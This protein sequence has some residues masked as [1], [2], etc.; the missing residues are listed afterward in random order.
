MKRRL[1]NIFLILALV[2]SLSTVAFAQ[3]GTPDRFE[4]RD[5]PES[6]SALKLDTPVELSAVLDQS[7]VGE[8]KVVGSAI[9]KAEY[10]PLM[11]TRRRRPISSDGFLWTS[12]RNRRR[13]H[14]RGCRPPG[15][16]V[17]SGD[18]AGG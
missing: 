18:A 4:G 12:H 2:L 6:V 9:E 10:E 17:R 7:L 15:F 5:V 8:V 14:R 16:R 11:S 13:G 1:L 3:D